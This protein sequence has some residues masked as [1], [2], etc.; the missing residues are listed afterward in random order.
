MW[1]LLYINVLSLFLLQ[2][3]IVAIF[4]KIE[5]IA[6]VYFNIYLGNNIHL[7]GKNIKVIETQLS[8]FE[9]LRVEFN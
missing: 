5:K 4:I 8:D 9:A 3:Y 2:Y 7:A 6:G 1:F